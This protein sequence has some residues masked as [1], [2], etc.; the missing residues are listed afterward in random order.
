[1]EKWSSDKEIKWGLKDRYGNL[2]LGTGESLSGTATIKANF[3]DII[4]DSN[5]IENFY[6]YKK[7][8]DF[9]INIV[10]IIRP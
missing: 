3:M 4:R 10:Y 7:P 8:L 5:S 2:I 9:I 1:M 6:E